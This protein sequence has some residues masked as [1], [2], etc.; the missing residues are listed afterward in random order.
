VVP[1]KSAHTH[2]ACSQDAPGV[3]SRSRLATPL[4]NILL[5]V[6][7]DAGC[8]A[9]GMQNAGAS[10]VLRSGRHPAPM[11]ES[12]HVGDETCAPVREGTGATE[13][14]IGSVGAESSAATTL[15]QRTLAC[16]RLVHLKPAIHGVE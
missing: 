3:S 1:P 10:G 8:S 14:V 6:A 7:S 11:S 13:H 5:F 4:S 2:G 16:Q 12:S 9:V 15:P